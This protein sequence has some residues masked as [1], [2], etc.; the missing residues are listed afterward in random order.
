MTYRQ[1]F[2]TKTLDNLKNY[3]IVMNH[4]DNNIYN[5]ENQFM[6]INPNDHA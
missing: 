5:F 1:I 4:Y 2:D 6:I 3:G